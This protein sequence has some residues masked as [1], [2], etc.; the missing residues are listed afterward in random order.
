MRGTRV[1]AA[2]LLAALAAAPAAYGHAFPQAAT[3]GPDPRAVDLANE[4]PAPQG[5]PHGEALP[6]Q[7]PLASASKRKRALRKRKRAK[8]VT[9]ALPTS[10]CGEVRTSDDREHERD[11]GGPRYHA[12]YAVPSDAS[13]R[14]ESLAATLQTDAFQAS[15]LLER[16]YGRAIRFDM[17]TNCGPQYLDISLLRLPQ[18]SSQLSGLASSY[19]GTINAVTNA[20]AAAGFPASN[21]ADSWS[22]GSKR[23]RNFLVWL[24][25]P[26]PSGACGQG[27]LY[28]DPT[29][30]EWN[31]NNQ[32]GRVAM[33]FRSGSGFCGSNTVRH[34][35]GHNLGA[36]QPGAPHAFDGAHCDDAYE[37]TM[38]YASAPR[39]SS[40]SFQR[41]FFDY[42]NDDY[43]DPPSGPPLS[44]WT[45]NLS[46]FV[47]LAPD[48]N[49]VE[50]HEGDRDGDGVPDA[51]DNCPATPN[52]GQE[53]GFGDGRG[54]ACEP[55][56]TL[57]VLSR[58]GRSWRLAV[59]AR[60]QGP[61]TVTL[62]C[63]RRGRTRT[64]LRRSVSLPAT[65]T[66]R[67]ACA[68]RPVA[69]VST[70]G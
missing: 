5:G 65:V 22:V 56:S 49:A 7:A 39:R 54:D 28:D 52:P 11:T 4:A 69:I 30:A 36:L 59:R 58:Y 57:K 32:G 63:R 37:D 50:G 19:T 15:A 18:T 67:V 26:G 13:S 33:V 27:T 61:A 1:I 43:W 23:T 12:V 2:C 53:N 29:R 51:A 48:C 25:G 68:S 45:V 8:A 3:H 66:A 34:E 60:G 9:Q 35:I 64:V 70:P 55:R 44:H 38:C 62:R 46:R 10:W 24:D 41:L 17:G 14:L 42:G 47:C 20:L 21:S 6:A 40:G 31:A 16:L